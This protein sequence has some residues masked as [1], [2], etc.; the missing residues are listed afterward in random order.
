MDA[1]KWVDFEARVRELLTAG[2]ALFIGVHQNLSWSGIGS[3]ITQ[4]GTGY[5]C[6]AQYLSHVVSSPNDPSGLPIGTIDSVCADGAKVR[7]YDFVNQYKADVM[8]GNKE[9]TLGVIADATEE[10]KIDTTIIGTVGDNYSWDDI[11]RD[12]AVTLLP[13]INN[14]WTWFAGQLD[15]TDLFHA[16]NT[17][18]CSADCTDGVRSVYPQFCGNVNT[19][20]VTPTMF[21]NDPLIV[22]DCKTTNG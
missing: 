2:N 9:L 16:K 5:F 15:R 8:A 19:D 18:D 11:V 3:L 6:H 13:M 1:K 14:A 22:K 17:Y 4:W 12:G 20:N 21:M 10:A 7:W